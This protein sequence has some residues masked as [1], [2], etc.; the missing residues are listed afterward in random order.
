MSEHPDV[1]VVGAG[2]GGLL[3]AAEVARRGGHPLVLEAGPVSG[4]VAASVHDEN[5]LLE[6]AAGSFLLPH[7]HLTPILESVGA[8]VVPA[9]PVAHRRYVYDRGELFE[10]AGPTSLATRLVSTRGKL[11]LFREPWVQTQKMNTDESLRSFLER[12]LGPEVGR[13]GATL[14]AHGVF[15]GDPNKLSV[16]AAF[17]AITALEDIAGSLARGFLA[18][19][20]AR[21][22]DAP[23]A[24]VH[25]A[26]N[27]MDELAS[28]LA[29]S[30]G[31]NFRPDWPVNSVQR[32]GG[33]WVIIG[34][35]E[36]RAPS[37]VVALA[38]AKAAQVV[39]EAF[40]P[41]LNEAHAAPVAVV[42]LG[43]HE[44]DLPVLSGFGV[45]T[46]PDCG[47][48]ILGLLFESSYAPGRAPAHHH[49]LKG[50]YGGDADPTVLALSDDDLVALAIEEAGQILGMPFQPTWTR[51]I[52]HT[53][54]IPQYNVGHLAWLDRL[55]LISAD[56]P[57]LHLAGWGYRAMGV[58]SLA[59]HAAALADK[60]LA[61]S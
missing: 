6:P 55:D 50:I 12:R 49:L 59:Q 25:I 27:G 36:E 47:L 60:V 9:E 51:V 16:R 18:R 28:E 33:E 29:V 58:T 61:S 10:F 54:G 34:R 44:A 20:R 48:R 30:L 52:R 42:G 7:P 32:D 2:L 11:Q 24:K 57:G 37:V 35:G 14:M 40:T 22:K 56:F 43:G 39:P 1:V 21:S 13:M 19:R 41:L 45:L 31:G 46:G 4:G 3:V 26:P 8:G 38:P 23:R 15:A 17:P 53:P 5:Y